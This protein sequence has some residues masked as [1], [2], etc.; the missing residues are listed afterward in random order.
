[1]NRNCE[2]CVYNTDGSCSQ[3]ECPGTTTIEDI[4]KQGYDEGFDKANK[5]IKPL[6]EKIH[7]CVLNQG[8]IEAFDE[9]ISE[10]KPRLN[11]NDD[12]YVMAIRH[13]IEIAERLKEGKKNVQ[14]I[15]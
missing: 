7:N 15:N 4:R 12:L 6:M 5:L 10:I 14:E 8:K 1:M 9:F 2:K 11:W 13:C 3:W